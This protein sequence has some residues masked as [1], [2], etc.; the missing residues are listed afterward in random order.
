MYVGETLMQQRHIT[1]YALVEQSLRGLAD[2]R[3]ITEG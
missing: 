1:K 3:F 2:L